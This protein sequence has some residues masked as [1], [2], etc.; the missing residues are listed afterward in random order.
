MTAAGVDLGRTGHAR[1]ALYSV[2][3]S[4]LTKLG[5]SYS[6][7]S[8]KRTR[9]GDQFASQAKTFSRAAPGALLADFGPMAG[10][11]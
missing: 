5:V 3:A 7:P 9:P 4:T 2:V 8:T 6:M 1:S 10:I 11:S